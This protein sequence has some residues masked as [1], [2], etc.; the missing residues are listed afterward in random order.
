MCRGRGHRPSPARSRSLRSRLPAQSE[1]EDGTGGDSAL[2]ERRQ[3]LGY[4]TGSDYRVAAV[5][6]ADEL[7]QELGAQS[8]AVAFD[9]VDR[10]M[11]LALHAG[12]CLQ[13][14]GCEANS[15]EKVA[16]AERRNITAPSGC[17]HAPRPWTSIAHFSRRVM[18]SRLVPRSAILL[19]ASE[20][21]RS[22]KKHGPH[23]AELSSARYRMMRAVSQTPHLLAGCTPITPQPSPTPPARRASASRGKSHALAA[24]SQLPK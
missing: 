22:P 19:Q 15:S 11:H 6:E 8:V 14:A 2:S 24:G 10:Q 21:A 20:S 3:A 13:W 5:V 17:L 7:W 12:C 1:G 4:G 16:S 23:C 9:P 18:S